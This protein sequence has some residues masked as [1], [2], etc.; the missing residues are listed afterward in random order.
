MCNTNSESGLIQIY[1]I[2]GQHPWVE[3]DDGEEPLPTLPSSLASK[4]SRTV[5]TGLQTLAAGHFVIA[6]FGSC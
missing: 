3:M 5:S 1:K 2:Q 4:H 6:Q